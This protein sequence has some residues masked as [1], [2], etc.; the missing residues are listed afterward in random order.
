MTSHEVRSFALTERASNWL[1][2][3]PD[4]DDAVERL[5][6][7]RIEQEYQ[8]NTKKRLR[9]IVEKMIADSNSKHLEPLTEISKQNLVR[10]I[11]EVIT[12]EEDLESLLCW[13][14]SCIE[15]YRQNPDSKTLDAIKASKPN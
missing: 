3:Q 11:S 14:N 2:Q 4:Q 8:E 10:A 15:T 6:D 5:I 12:L 9:Q 1:R 13:I 7:E